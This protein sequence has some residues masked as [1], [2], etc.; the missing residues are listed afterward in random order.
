MPPKSTLPEI[1]HFLPCDPDC[2]KQKFCKKI[3][4]KVPPKIRNFFY[5]SPVELPL[6]FILSFCLLFTNYIIE[7]IGITLSGLLQFILEALCIHF[8]FKTISTKPK[9][10]SNSYMG[11]THNDLIAQYLKIKFTEFKTRLQEYLTSNNL[12]LDYYA[13][14]KKNPIEILISIFKP[15]KKDFKFIWAILII[16]TIHLSLYYFNLIYFVDVLRIILTAI[17]VVYVTKNIYS[18]YINSSL[19]VDSFKS[20]PLQF[21]TS[22]IALGGLSALTI[23]ATM[24]IFKIIGDSTALTTA[25]LGI[26]G[27]IIAVFGLIK[28]HQKSELEREQLDT[29]KKKDTQ[30]YVR[31]VHATRRSR[32]IE[33][34]DKLTSDHASA[35]LGGV[36][37]LIGLI[38]EWIT[39]K[40]IKRAS[41][42]KE[43]QIIISNLCVYIRSPFLL[44]EKRE[45]LSSL[46]HKSIYVGDFIADKAKLAGEQ[47]VR[48]AIFTEISKRLTNKDNKMIYRLWNK[49]E[50]DF[51]KAPIF[52]SLKNMTFRNPDFSDA[53]FSGEA[54][55]RDCVFKG[56][57]NFNNAVFNGQADFSCSE[58]T[59]ITFEGPSD[60]SGAS[61]KGKA[62]FKGTV[63]EGE[64]IFSSNDS[65]WTNFNKETYFSDS[66][67]KSNATFAKAFFRGYTN[68]SASF[69][70]EADF[71][72][73]TFEH[74][75]EFNNSV[76]IGHADFRDTSF[77]MDSE[78]QK[79]EFHG[80]ASFLIEGGPNISSGYP[81]KGNADFTGAY[82]AKTATFADRYFDG[83]M[84]FTDAIFEG[85]AYFEDGRTQGISNFDRAYFVDSSR[86]SN[87][88]F[89]SSSTFNNACFA[90]RKSHEFF[91]I[92]VQIN[93][94]LGS[95]PRSPGNSWPQNQIPI[96]SRYGES[97]DFEK[98]T[99]A[100][101]SHQAV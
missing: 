97:W 12:P 94:P 2:G 5:I 39:D 85:S 37:A 74:K 56:G 91:S 72:N 55:F 7:K 9:Y 73:A 45:A 36:Y 46:P 43:G 28:S 10:I 82:F 40:S 20:H 16:L 53:V 1:Q 57:A 62:Y 6:L 33:A 80:G 96:G 58:P 59:K 3:W 54:D 30:E 4:E 41:R 86:F 23:P 95:V 88:F 34:I 64:A 47:E 79:T 78:F 31:Q 77:L 61:F 15:Q 70:G 51:S 21:F 48:H 32:Y 67:F 52:Y 38:D 19:I 17:V 42:K 76:I 49:F 65:S 8:F 83:D 92:N 44:A 87:H 100:I 66:S 35:R 63:F 93:L 98:R 101:K 50:Y 14:I 84:I 24:N 29:Q 11:F 75:V 27:G 68:F 18:A 99:F 69:E 13:H 81:F 89:G 22:I 60:F 26:T 90:T 71:F 25:M